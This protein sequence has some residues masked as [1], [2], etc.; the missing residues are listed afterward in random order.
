MNKLE[1]KFS[2]S[3][4]LKFGIKMFINSEDIGGND[5]KCNTLLKC[6]R[7]TPYKP[8]AEY[9]IAAAYPKA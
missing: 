1:P 6:N 2:V 8:V 4:L 3:M 9:S 5:A 7:C